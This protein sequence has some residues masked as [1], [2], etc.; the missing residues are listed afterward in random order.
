MQ[1]DHYWTE[2]QWKFLKKCCDFNLQQHNIQV[3]VSSESVFFEH[4]SFETVLYEG[5]CIT[6]RVLTSRGSESRFASIPAEY[7]QEG[8]HVLRPWVRAVMRVAFDYWT[9]GLTIG[10]SESVRTPSDWTE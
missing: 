2:T 5:L 3:Q 6:G 4:I 9:M 8:K 10:T 1:K 7:F